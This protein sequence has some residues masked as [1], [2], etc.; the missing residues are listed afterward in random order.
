[1]RVVLPPDLD[2]LADPCLAGKA[3]LLQDDADAL[4]QLGGL[5]GGVEAEHGDRAPGP[6]A[7]ALQNLHRRGLARAVRPEQAEHLAL[8][9][10][11]VDAAQHLPL[12]V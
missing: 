8:A 1:V 3:A 11:E 12:P 2:Q 4:A 7:E 5:G 6:R 10:L 9:D